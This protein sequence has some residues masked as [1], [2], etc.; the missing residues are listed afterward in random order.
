MKPSLRQRGLQVVLVAA[1]SCPFGLAGCGSQAD[2]SSGADDPTTQSVS[3][4]ESE[5]AKSKP[6]PKRA[7]K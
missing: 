3:K 5:I 6:A 4:Y 2:S 1:A 7:A